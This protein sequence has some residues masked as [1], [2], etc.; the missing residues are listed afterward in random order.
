MSSV[1]DSIGLQYHAGRM[2]EFMRHTGDDMVSIKGGIERLQADQ[3]ALQAVVAEHSVRSMEAS[4]DL[5]EIKAAMAELHAC[6]EG[7]SIHRAKHTGRWKHIG[8]GTV[9]TLGGLTVL[10]TL[11]AGKDGD[12]LDTL[13]LLLGILT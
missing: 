3:Q 12:V 2:E 5:G 7:Q 6:M 8:I 11:L 9:L 4:K 1:P 10:V 13:S